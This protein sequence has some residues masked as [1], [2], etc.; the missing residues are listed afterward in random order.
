MKGTLSLILILL[1]LIPE[2][3][4]SESWL[5]YVRTTEDRWSIYRH[6]NNLSFK[7]D[8]YIKGEIEPFYGPRGRVLRPSCSYF[9][10]INLNDVNLK[11]RTAALEGNYS[12]SATIRSESKVKPPVGLDFYKPVDSKIYAID[13][14]ETWP[15]SIY[16]S[17]R[18]EYSGKRI[19]DRDFSVN[20]YDFIGTNLL[21]N[22]KLSKDLVVK[23]NLSR[24][25]YTVLAAESN[26]IL[27][28]SKPTRDLSFRLSTGTTG[29]ADIK[30]QQS[31][32][33]FYGDPAAKYRMVQGEERYYGLFN[34]TMNIHM[35]SQFDRIKQEDDWL[36]C[37]YQGWAD[38]RLADKI[39]I[40]KSADDIFSCKC[41][42]VHGVRP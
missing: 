26:V 29:M 7:S 5:G 4:L 30:Y 16:A 36:P 8:Q 22:T 14:L 1:I 33:E 11:Q 6:S 23:M 18:L 41:A 38:M 17:K 13:F 10:D 9:E 2:M 37:C 21:Y 32:P 34:L 24:M 35:K 39:A 12:S 27:V 3:A 42:G 15:V 31:Q 19:N 20:N 28:E 40:T 25:N